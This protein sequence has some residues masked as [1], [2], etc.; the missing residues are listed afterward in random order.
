MKRIKILAII[1]ML[2]P[3]AV[4]CGKD[5][6]SAPEET[7]TGEFIDKDTGEPFQTANGNTGIRIRMM[8]YSWSD[9]PT[10][11]DFYVMQ[12]G[13]FNNTKIFKGQYGVTPAGAF[14]PLEEEIIDI[15]GTV[16]K[17]YEV[18]PFLRIEWIGEPVLNSDGTVD[19]T[20]KI[21]RGTD[22]ADYQQDLAE[23]WLFV[24]QTQYCSDASFS[25]SFSTHVTGTPLQLDQE[26]TIR[27]G[28]PN[29]LPDDLDNTTVSPR[30]F[31]TYSTKYFLRVGA[32]TNI[33]ITGVNKYNYSTIKEITTTAR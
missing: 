11:Y 19:V 20:V 22:N 5:N 32:R 25:G 15:E 21:T 17:T 29:G 28:Y 18:E 2:I 13:T 7:F 3:L 33:Q 30:S 12:D 8:E 4:S 31:P 24:S 1:L 16:K 9:T 6:Y 10:P 23:A 26:I 27:S 14:V